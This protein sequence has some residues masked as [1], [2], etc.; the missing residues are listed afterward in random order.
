M[1]ARATTTAT[2]FTAAMRHWITSLSVKRKMG[3]MKRCYAR[4]RY[5]ET[6]EAKASKRA[7]K[8]R[9]DV[10]EFDP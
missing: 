3:G 4:R 2:G 8:C 7:G 6:N 1:T 5:E 10:E 9:K